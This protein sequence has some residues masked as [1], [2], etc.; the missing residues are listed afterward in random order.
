[1]LSRLFLFSTR[2]KQASCHSQDITYRSQFHGNRLILN[3]FKHPTYVQS[4]NSAL[5]RF[6]AALSRSESAY[7][8]ER[9]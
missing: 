6:L 8:G 2:M 3:Y 5:F 9:L 4:A 7:C 1:M